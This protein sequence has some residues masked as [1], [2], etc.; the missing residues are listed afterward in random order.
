MRRDIQTL[1]YMNAPTILVN[2]P[3]Q[4]VIALSELL[5]LLNPEP[6]GLYED[7]LE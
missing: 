4:Q 1:R 5:S 3:T 6:L 2:Q 7:P